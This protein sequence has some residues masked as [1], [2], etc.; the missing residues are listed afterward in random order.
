M[1]GLCLPHLVVVRTLNLVIGTAAWDREKLVYG[2]PIAR[3][4]VASDDVLDETWLT[5]YRTTFNPARLRL[6]AMT[7]EMPHQYWANMPETGLIPDM[8]ASAGLR[9]EEMAAAS[10][11]PAPR[12][13]EVIAA[14]PLPGLE[15]LGDA[16]GVLRNEIAAC[17]RCPLHCNATQAVT[18]EG[19][20][21]AKIMLVVALGAT[22]AGALAGHQLSGTKERGRR[23]FGE[24]RGFV[25]VR[26]SFLLRLPDENAQEREYRNFV[27]DLIAV[28]SLGLARD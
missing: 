20:S 17:R 25:T 14:R 7:A 23:Q 1:R 11:R 28:R 9:V 13:A 10:P 22:A 3:P 6:K 12:F 24:R 4:A 8:V 27:N 15:D 18:G 21:N 5:Y 19:P 16:L 2:P 26:P